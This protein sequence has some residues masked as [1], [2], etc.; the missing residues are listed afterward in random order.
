[1]ISAGTINSPQ[2]LEL[3]GIGEP[4]RLR[5][6]G[7]EVRHALP[8]VGENLRDRTDA[9]GDKG[10]HV[11]RSRARCWSGWQAMRYALL[12]QGLL[13]MVAAPIRAFVR[14]REGLEAPDVLLEVVGTD[15][16]RA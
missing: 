1:M 13:G 7:I 10:H 6:L 4:E 9:V 2:L 16:T 11:Q 5:S 12:G 3:S 15:G 14:S 8:D